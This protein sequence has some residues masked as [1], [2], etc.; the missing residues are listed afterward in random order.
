MLFSDFNR[1]EF[2]SEWRSPRIWP[3]SWLN[4]F[5]Y[6]S[7]V[8]SDS[9]K[10]WRDTKAKLSTPWE[11]KLAE[12]VEVG[13]QRIKDRGQID[14]LQ[15]MWSMVEWMIQQPYHNPKPSFMIDTKALLRTNKFVPESDE[16]KNTLQVK[17]CCDDQAI[18]D[19]IHKSYAAAKS[20]E[21]VAEVLVEMVDLSLIHI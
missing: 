16:L 9:R 6:K 4:H 17:R 11:K 3:G 10:V 2:N 7:M 5:W 20:K 18:M 1:K 14:E 15:K 13:H 21:G 12:V 8:A 19:V